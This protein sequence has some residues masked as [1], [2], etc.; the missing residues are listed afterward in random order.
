MYYS[1]S[2]LFTSIF[3]VADFLLSFKAAFGGDIL[4][5]ENSK[6]LSPSEYMLRSHE[7]KDDPIFSKSY[8]IIDLGLDVGIGSDCGKVDF[9]GTMRAALKNTLDAKYFGDLGRDIMAASPMLATCYFS[10]TWCSVLKQ[11]QLSAHF[12]SQ[13]R[14]NQCALI[15]KY[16]DDRTEDF[17]RERQTCVRK[18]IGRQS[19]NLESALSSCQN[20]FDL[21]LTSWTGA[22][23]G[24]GKSENRLIESSA[25]WAGLEGDRA[26]EAVNLAKAFVGDTVVSKGHISVDYGPKKVPTTPYSHLVDL[27]EKEYSVLCDDLLKKIERERSAR[28]VDEIITYRDLKKL[29]GDGRPLI[30]K[31]TIQA[32]SF[33]PRGARDEACRKLSNEM[34]LTLFTKQMNDTLDVL[35]VASQNP[36]LPPHR[37]KEIDEK[38]AS[39]KE[40]TDMTLKLH[41]ERNGPL[42][43]TVKAINEE[44][45]RYRDEKTWRSLSVDRAKTAHDSEAAILFDCGDSVWCSKEER[46]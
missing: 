9:R 43:E 8:Q 25:K 6:R 29:S 16:T 34:A 5:F 17:Y 14:L 11:G 19:G 30:D 26:G 1:M 24:D 18:E 7:N 42:N 10:P 27:Q 21:D 31:E 45:G 38:R 13:M 20:P 22:G 32:M 28:T 2:R 41:R 23:R 33:L 15:D 35:T 37:K 39:L 40:S 12:L 4:N 3:I 46:R 44:G 36:N